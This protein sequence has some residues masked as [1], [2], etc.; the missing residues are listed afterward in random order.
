MTKKKTK[1]QSYFLIDSKIN[2]ISKLYLIEII[3]VNMTGLNP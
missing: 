3:S 2:I 1:L